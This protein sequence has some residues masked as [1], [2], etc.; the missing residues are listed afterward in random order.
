MPVYAD[1]PLGLSEF[2]V[3]AFSLQNPTP[4]SGWSVQ[5]DLARRPGGVPFFSA[6]LA[7]GFDG[8]S[9]ITL[10]NGAIGTFTVDLPPSIMSGRDPG[11]F[12]Y[13]IHRSNS[14]FQTDLTLGYRV[15]A[16]Y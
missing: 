8:V 12:G 4:I 5:F 7:S 3:V 11:N 2:G 6:Y 15:A 9:G 14:G 16:N 10:V 13:K 1:F